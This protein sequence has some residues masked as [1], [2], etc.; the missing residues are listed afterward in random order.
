MKTFTLSQ[1]MLHRPLILAVIGLAMGI[2]FLIIE[3][4]W[5]ILN[6]FILPE[7]TALIFTAAALP[8][9][10]FGISLANFRL[11]KGLSRIQITVD[12]NLSI[13]LPKKTREVSFDRIKQVQIQGDSLRILTQDGG[14]QLVG[15]Q[16]A[17]DLADLLNSITQSQNAKE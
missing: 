6:D 16:D 5:L 10:M 4:V 11:R 8:L 14:M 7:Q 12:Q 17:Q 2:G 9:L 1:K 3:L 13:R 15:V